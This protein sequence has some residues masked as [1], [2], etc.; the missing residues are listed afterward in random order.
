MYNPLTLL[1]TSVLHDLIGNGHSYFIRQSYPRGKDDHDKAFRHAFLITQYSNWHDAVCHYVAISSD[2]F[3]HCY[4][5]AHT[6]EKEKLFIAASQPGGYRVFVNLLHQKSWELPRELELQVK[7][8]IHVRL[9]WLPRNG[10]NINM[11]LEVHH[12]ELFL[13]LKFRLLQTTVRLA[14]IEKY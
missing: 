10:E 2:P 8:Y 1:T 4:D 5:I 6:F 14:D 7:R 9:S 11:Q 12:G 3:K 13:T